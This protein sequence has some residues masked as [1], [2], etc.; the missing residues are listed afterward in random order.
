MFWKFDRAR[1]R[2]DSRSVQLGCNLAID[3]GTYTF[4]VMNESG[5]PADVVARIFDPFFTTKPVGKGTGL[6]LALSYGIVQNHHGNITV[7]STPG[8]GTTF[9]ITLPVTQPAD[10]GETR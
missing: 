1:G 2:I 9:R 3:M 4:A 8:A 6:G 7:S 5:T 10:P